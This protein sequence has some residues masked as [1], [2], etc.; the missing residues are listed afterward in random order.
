[1]TVTKVGPATV[2][3]NTDM[4]YTIT[5]TNNGPADATNVTL[6]DTL[7]AGETLVGF[8]FHTSPAPPFT[9][10]SLIGTIDCSTPSMPVGSQVSADVLVHVASGIADGTVLTNTASVSTPDQS[11]PNTA[12]NQSTAATTVQL[13]RTDLAVTKVGPA[14]VAPN[15]NMT[16]TIT[17]TNNGPADATN[18]T[19][20]DT[21]PAGETLVGFT[22]HTSPAPPFTTCGLIGT[23]ACS[24]PSM[25]VGSQVS[26]DVL[27]HVASGIADGTVL[28]N[29]AV[30]A[31]GAD[32]IDPTTGNNQ[33]T[34]ATT[35]QLPR[36]DL[37]VT[38]VGP[39]T[40]APNT[41]MTY[42]I[43][44]TNNGPADATNV[45][46]T[47]TLPAGETLVGFTFHTSPAPPFTTC[48]LIGTIDCSTPSMPVG[49]QVSADVLVHVASGIADGTVLNNTAVVA[50]GADQIDPTTGNN[51]STAATTVQLPRTDLAVTKVGPATVAP[52][53]NM[54]YTITWTNNGPADATN[55]ALTDTL[56]AGETLVGF[57]FHTSPAPPFTTCGLIGTIDCSTPSMPAGSQVS[58]DVLVHVAGD[59]PDCTVL[60]NTAAVTGGADQIDPTTGNNQ[61][62]TAAVVNSGAGTCG[63]SGGDGG[64]GN[65]GA[66]P[67]LDSLLLFAAGLSGLAGY[68][69]TRRR[70]RGR[71]Q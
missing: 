69:A 46:L 9:T 63:G 11:D 3:P 4:T 66:T 1:L 12:N 47:D 50:G 22:F 58:A 56:P 10:C 29:T 62:T 33:S 61:S 31:G 8:T 54:T 27:V 64:G 60:S 17:W 55:V 7:P 48:G 53:T 44:W 59:L 35:V 70:A 18:V 45:T 24:T 52:N 28:S 23:I 6:T 51:Q 16:Y 49:S 41:N 34:A 26:A 13:L 67:E 36:T 37:A 32:Q 30:V 21:L 2:A 57:T 25:P 19:L 14:T 42:T 65:P 43:T 15:T 20:T 40:V 39:A 71:R 68:A 5:W 38:K